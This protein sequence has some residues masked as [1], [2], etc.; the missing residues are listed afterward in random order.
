MR[1]QDADRA[2]E[3]G[4]TQAHL[5]SNAVSPPSQTKP[6]QPHPTVD[7]A[8]SHFHPISI[9]LLSPLPR[10][11]LSTLLCAWP[12]SA[13]PD[14]TCSFLTG[15]L[16]RLPQLKAQQDGITLI[17]SSSPLHHTLLST[18]LYAQ[19]NS[20]APSCSCSFLTRTLQRLLQFLLPD[21]HIPAPD[22]TQHSRGRCH[23]HT[24]WITLPYQLGHAFVSTSRR[25]SL[26]SR[27]RAVMTRNN[28]SRGGKPR[29]SDDAARDADFVEEAPSGSDFDDQPVDISSDGLKSPASRRLKRK[30][31]QAS[32]TVVS[33]DEE[34]SSEAPPKAKKQKDPKRGEKGKKQ[35]LIEQLV[36]SAQES[37]ASTSSV[38][39]DVDPV[40]FNQVH[41]NTSKLDFLINQCGMTLRPNVVSS[42]TPTCLSLRYGKAVDGRLW[43]SSS[44]PSLAE[45]TPFLYGGR[46][47]KTSQD[48]AVQ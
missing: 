15:T 29:A 19:P 45:M 46:S 44:T 6:S 42:Y 18:L 2:S 47:C 43:T 36:A 30:T 8:P 40:T 32:K 20:A 7:L 9:T 21:R 16:Q 38:A 26:T 27:H 34:S 24:N 28:P 12:N 25:S 1:E 10:P 39:S 4:A 11:L 22:C 23:L 37:S 5:A 33:S 14:F 3:E 13:T 41:K 31:R 17:S 48:L 35:S